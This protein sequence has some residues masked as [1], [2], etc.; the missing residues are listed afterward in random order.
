[1][2]ARNNNGY[3]NLKFG[4]QP[5]NINKTNI[6]FDKRT[7]LLNHQSSNKKTK[8]QLIYSNVIR[9]INSNTTKY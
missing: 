2:F 8:A 4:K 3:N 6:N 5:K 1:M 7:S 9:Q